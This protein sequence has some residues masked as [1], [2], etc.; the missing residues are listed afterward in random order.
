MK[1]LIVAVDKGG[2]F[3]P[4]IEEQISALEGV[5]IVVSRYGV[6]GKGVRGYLREIPQLR[7]IIRAEHPDI[8]HAHYGLCG[9]LTALANGKL[10]PIKV[11]TTYHGSDINDRK[12]LHLS[13]MAMMMSDWNIFVSRKNIATSFGNCGV[14][15]GNYSLIPCG[16]DA[17]DHPLIPYSSAREQ[18][19][20]TLHRL[21]IE[22]ETPFVLFAGAFKNPVKDAAL[23]QEV[24]RQLAQDGDGTS[25][26][27]VELS[28]YSRHEVNLLMSAAH[29]LLL[30]SKSEGSPQVIKE[31]L[32]CGCPIVSVDVGDV[33]ER[34]EGVDGCY[35]ASSRDPQELADLLRRAFTFTPPYLFADNNES[36]K[37]RT[38]GREHLLSMGLDNKQVAHAI[39]AI[40]SSL[41]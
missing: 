26:P 13:R 35:V 33:R 14:K 36:Q 29:C 17:T 40:Y 34:V 32:A 27:L 37:P 18:L 4:F 15:I 9:L 22:K 38:N 30:T 11:I 10:S 6:H 16:V 41:L 25:I 5:G 8:I 3:T 28:G 23:A 2:C 12:V 1:V 21:G 24:M 31:A 19:V 20:D 7:R 39:R